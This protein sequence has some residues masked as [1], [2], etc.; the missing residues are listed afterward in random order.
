MHALGPHVH[1][2]AG[3]ALFV[4]PG[5]FDPVLTKVGEWLATVAPDLVQPGESWLDLGTGTGIVALALGRAGARVTAVDIDPAA[6]R[7]AQMNAL[8]HQLP[9]LVRQGNLFDAVAGQR[10]DGVVANLPFW[11]DPTASL[12]LGHAFAAGKEYAILRQFTAQ[13]NTFSPRGYLVLSES[14]ADFAGARAALGRGMSLMRRA[15]HRGEWMNL[16]ERRSSS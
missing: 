15:R 2:P 3:H 1:H 11:P 10:F 5:V 14:F 12:P 16:F 13:V 8:L 9:I 4:A 7:N 6:C